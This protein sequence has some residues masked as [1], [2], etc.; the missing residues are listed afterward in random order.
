MTVKKKRELFPGMP[1]ALLKFGEC[2]PQD[3]IYKLGSGSLT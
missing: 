2:F 1:P 3:F